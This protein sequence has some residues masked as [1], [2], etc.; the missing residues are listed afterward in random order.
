MFQHISILFFMGFVGCHFS[1]SL[2][3]LQDFD[4]I[5]TVIKS[6]IKSATTQQPIAHF[7]AALLQ[8][9]ARFTRDLWYRVSSYK[10]RTFCSRETSRL[11]VSKTTFC[12]F[13]FTSTYPESQSLAYILQELSFIPAFPKRYSLII[14][15]FSFRNLELWCFAYHMQH[16]QLSTVVVFCV[17]VS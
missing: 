13:S 3:P 4:N 5:I 9:Y 8:W 2:L 12:G 15:A 10:P 14:S 11:I 7:H 6:I 17:L 16:I 1:F